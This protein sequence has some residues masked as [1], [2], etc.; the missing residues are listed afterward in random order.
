MWEKGQLVECRGDPVVM[1]GSQVKPRGQWRHGWRDSR[2][3]PEQ[4]QGWPCFLS[5]RSPVGRFGD[6]GVG[7]TGVRTAG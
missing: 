7:H 4:L 5:W 3:G 6:L 1:A 2:W